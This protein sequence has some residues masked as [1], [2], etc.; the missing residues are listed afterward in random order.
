MRSQLLRDRRS[1]LIV[2]GAAFRLEEL[3]LNRRDVSKDIRV[4]VAALGQINRL[5]CTSSQL[6]C[7]SFL[8]LLSCRHL[9]LIK[10]GE[11]RKHI[12]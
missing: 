2:L 3:T 12:T 4:C 5:P 7:C 10:S 9:S 11:L 8:H 6:A 1:E